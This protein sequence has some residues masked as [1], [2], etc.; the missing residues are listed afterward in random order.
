MG[1]WGNVLI[2]HLLPVI[3][4]SYPCHYT[5][6]CPH[7]S[8]QH[9]HTHTHTDTQS[10]ISSTKITSKMNKNYKIMLL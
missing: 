2:N 7:M 5:N 10:V 4:V 3:P 1:T 8:Q 6:L 9:A